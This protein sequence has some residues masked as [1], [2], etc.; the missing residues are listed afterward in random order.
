M[1]YSFAFRTFSSI[2]HPTD[3][4]HEH[5]DVHCTVQDGEDEGAVEDDFFFVFRGEAAGEADGCGGF[6]FGAVAVQFDPGFVGELFVLRG[7]CGQGGEVGGW[8]EGFGDA[9][10]GAG[11]LYVGFGFNGEFG[12]ACADGCIGGALLESLEVGGCEQ[13]AEGF[14]AF[15]FGEQGCEGVVTLLEVLE[16]SGGQVGFDVVVFCAVH[17]V[18]FGFGSGAVGQYA[19]GDQAVFR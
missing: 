18:H 16:G 1:V 19:L 4:S 6:G 10:V 13:P 7:G 5:R 15:F 9:Q 8:G 3:N 11:L 14:R 2:F 17:H 12:H